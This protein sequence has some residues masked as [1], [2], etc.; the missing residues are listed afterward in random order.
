MGREGQ[1]PRPVTEAGS[2][3]L[4]STLYKAPTGG[5]PS[6]VAGGDRRPNLCFT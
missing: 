3:V 2:N 5:L 4:N 1:S 6:S